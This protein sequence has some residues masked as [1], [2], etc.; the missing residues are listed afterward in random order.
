MTFFLPTDLVRFR[1]CEIKRNSPPAKYRNT[2][3]QTKIQRS[4]T[5]S[6]HNNTQ[7]TISILIIIWRAHVVHYKTHS[8]VIRIIFSSKHKFIHVKMWMAWHQKTHRTSIIIYWWYSWIA[9][10]HNWI[11][12]RT[13]NRTYYLHKIIYWWIMKY[14]QRYCSWKITILK[15]NMYKHTNHL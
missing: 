3:N 14:I 2:M 6:Q 10:A 9:G 5:L 4:W 13:S 8:N 12:Y 7:V 1:Y 15:Y 11:Y